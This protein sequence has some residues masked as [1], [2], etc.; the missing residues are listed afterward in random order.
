M[1][2]SVQASALKDALEAQET[3]KLRGFNAACGAKSSVVI[4][5]WGHM[6]GVWQIYNGE[7]FWTN[8][9]SSQPSFRTANLDEA[10]AHTL[11]VISA[12]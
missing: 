11:T 10:I 8:G 2:A 3:L 9:A 1:D 12:G 6:R 5:R 4:D 7:Y